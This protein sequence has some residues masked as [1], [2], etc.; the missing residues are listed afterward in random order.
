MCFE[1]PTIGGVSCKGQELF[2]GLNFAQLKRGSSWFSW[3][4]IPAR[5]IRVKY[6]DMSTITVPGRFVGVCRMRFS[7]QFYLQPSLYFTSFVPQSWWACTKDQRAE[8]VGTEVVLVGC[9]VCFR[10]LLSRGRSPDQ[11]QLCS[12]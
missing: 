7:D 9:E 8:C 1:G 12:A 11:E 3:L 10:V 5:Y 6:C 2:I 4:H